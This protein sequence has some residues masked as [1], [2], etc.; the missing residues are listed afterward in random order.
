MDTSAPAATKVEA[1]SAE[2]QAERRDDG[3][4]HA[5]TAIWMPP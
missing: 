2:R 3:V 5:A 4:F 1:G